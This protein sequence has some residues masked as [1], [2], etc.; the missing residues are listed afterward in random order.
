MGSPN[1][2]F[3]QQTDWVS[4]S[5]S[6]VDAQASQEPPLGSHGRNWRPLTST[7]LVELGL[8]LGLMTVCVLYKIQSWK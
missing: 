6:Y 2:A 7:E 8:R 5:V 4:D 3:C 1:H